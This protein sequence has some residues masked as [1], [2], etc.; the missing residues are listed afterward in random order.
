MIRLERVLSGNVLSIY[1]S[2]DSADR[3]HFVTNVLNPEQIRLLPDHYDRLCFA[4]V[5]WMANHEPKN[6]AKLRSYGPKPQHVNDYVRDEFTWI[7]ACS[8]FLGLKLDHCPTLEERS[9]AFMEQQLPGIYRAF[10]VLRHPEKI[11]FG[12][13]EVNF[14]DGREVSAAA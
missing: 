7:H 5:K 10:Y 3:E 1:N 2:L 12:V 8:Y 9:Q 6:L 14:E 13:H 11:D 4:I